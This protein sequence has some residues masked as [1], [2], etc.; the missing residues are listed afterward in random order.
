MD[1]INTENPWYHISPADYENHMADPAVRQL[2]LLNRV[3]REQYRDYP[4]G[5][6]VYLG[7][8]TG[9]GLEHIDSEVTDTV[10]GLDV[11]E[12]FLALCADRY[13]TRINDL[14]L[15]KVDINHTLFEA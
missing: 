3:F 2:Q 9:N 11:N 12:E 15:V 13:G 10:W 5:S 14:R 6:L 8:C 7:I 4:P 1:L